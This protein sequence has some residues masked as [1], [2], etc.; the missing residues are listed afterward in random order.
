MQLKPLAALLIVVALLSGDIL[1]AQTAAPAA[2]KTTAKSSDKKPSDPAS[3]SWRKNKRA[4]KKL[5]KKGKAPQAI[6]YLEAG[7]QK[8]A[9]KVYF[10]QNLSSIE[11]SL[12]D[13]AASNK[14]YKVLVDKD[15]AKHKKPE[16]IFHY[17]L[18]Q[19]YLGEYE[20]AMINF[21]KYKKLAGDKDEVAD[22]KKRAT[23]ESMGCDRG[24]YYRD[25]V[26]KREFKVKRL[27]A[28]INQSST[29][30]APMPKD[31]ALYFNSQK[32]D[33]AII[34]KS[35]KNGKSWTA[36]EE[37]SPDINVSNA[38]VTAPAFSADGTTLYYTV[39]P[40]DNGQKVKPKCE[41]YKSKLT[42]GVW[43]KG[44]SAGA[45]VNDPLF[46]SMQPATGKNKDGEDVLYFV[47]DR[48]AGKG[49]DLYYSKINADGSLGKGRSVGSMINSKG[50]ETTPFFDVKSK[51]LYFSSNGLINIGGLDVFKTT[52]DANGDWTEPENMGTPVNSS[53][54][55]YYFS[56]NDKLT[57]G[58]EASNR[59]DLS[60]LKGGCNTCTDDIY[61]VET[62]R[63]FL[64]VTGNVFEDK[65][66]QKELVSTGSVSLYD[67]RNGTELGSYIPINGSYFFDLQPKRG[68]KVMTR[69]DGYFDGISTFNTD[70]NTE[71]D[72]LKYDLILKK[73]AEA[74]P[75]LGRII[76]RIYYDYDQARLRADSRDSLRKI[77]DIMNQFP[78][79]VFE[80]GAHTDGKGTEEYN[81]NLSKKR[82]DAAMGYFRYEKKISSDRLIP[83]AY[84][85]S[86]PVA[87]NKTPDGKDN[88][89]GRALNRR[90]EFKIVSELTAEQIAAQ[91]TVAPANN[92]VAVPIKET[93]PVAPAKTTP[94]TTAPVKPAPP[95]KI[96]APAP[97]KETKPTAP[98]KST[99][100]VPVKETNTVAPAKPAPAPAKETKTAP[101]KKTTEAPSPAAKPAEVAKVVKRDI[102]PAKA[103]PIPA[104]AA[105]PVYK[106][107]PARTVVLSGK[108]YTE[109]GGK[110][111]LANDAA[112][113]LTSDVDGFQQKVFYVKDGTGTYSFDLSRATPGNYK[114]IARK[115]KFESNEISMSL[116]HIKA[117]NVPID[118]EIQVK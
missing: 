32:G 1:T 68:Y 42:G 97:A 14:W 89:T 3:L 90:T 110:R 114:V 25:S 66:G 12:R 118:L 18:T 83:K 71:S 37:L 9:K 27:D 16:Y 58:Y 102:V 79:Y 20:A 95:V 24:I 105:A 62:T 49:L 92:N 107:A 21:A 46:N 106:P 75:L 65:D 41:I 64:A 77:M 72:T 78:N 96:P 61:M 47:S 8:K 13:Y 74:N 22:L 51:T 86:Q 103:A 38:N 31:R 94:V 52:W 39:C 85:T 73:R 84:G 45:G 101:A 15:S 5:I 19:K 6:P 67:D 26:T 76:G 44:T 29:D 93:K 112:V 100:P 108:V 43:E 109:K 56:M 115:D 28:N 33:N 88:P 2:G 40:N 81:L 80:V 7:A 82:A 4:A 55:D 36:A 99:A 60:M 116:D 104:P 117:V 113:F 111:M 17:A 63:L 10:A 98:A 69:R 30:F 34:Y 57:L 35:V 91:K 11:F 87:P 70:N 23:R 48:N 53:V 59:V 54:D 50:D